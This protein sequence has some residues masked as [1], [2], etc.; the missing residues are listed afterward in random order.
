MLQEGAGRITFATDTLP[1]QPALCNWAGKW[2]ISHPAIQFPLAAIERCSCLIH[3]PSD[4]L[5]HVQAV[6][7][8]WTHSGRWSVLCTLVLSDVEN[9]VCNVCECWHESIASLSALSTECKQTVYPWESPDLT[10]ELLISNGTSSIEIYSDLQSSRFCQGGCYPGLLEIIEMYSM[11]NLSYSGHCS[12]IDLECKELA[13]AASNLESSLLL[14]DVLTDCW[15]CSLHDY[16]A[17]Y[18]CEGI[19]QLMQQKELR[20][21]ISCRLREWT[22]HCGDLQISDCSFFCGLYTFEGC[23][24]AGGSEIISISEFFS[25]LLLKY[26]E[27]LLSKHVLESVLHHSAIRGCLVVFLFVS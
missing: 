12:V 20:Q 4:A 1:L 15:W 19:A 18:V 24:V 3:C 7:H 22:V 16:Y 9:H 14:S 6:W 27:E 2:L 5:L 25:C 21:R 10:S 8:I 17:E 13:Y 26:E 11:Y 23:S